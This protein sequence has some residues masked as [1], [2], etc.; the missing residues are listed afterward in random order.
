[1]S[2]KSNFEKVN[3]QILEK[4]Y[5]ELTQFINTLEK[6]DT[7]LAKKIRV[8][9]KK[10]CGN[11]HPEVQ[12]QSVY[13]AMKKAETCPLIEKVGKGFTGIFKKLE[14]N[15]TPSEI[16]KAWEQ[17]CASLNVAQIEIKGGTKYH[18]IPLE[19]LEKQSKNI[20]ELL[21][22][23][24][25]Q[26]PAGPLGELFIKCL[27]KHTSEGI[28]NEKNA[29]ALTQMGKAYGIDWLVYDCEIYLRKSEQL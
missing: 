6:T 10:L 27:E 16:D 24:K 29:L 12:A 20:K 19:L 7:E 2:I 26:V 21:H 1:M 15:S 18:N 25:L 11:T 17:L 13:R 23:G 3:K 22:E 8:I 28:V 9:Q 4:H 5:P 14:R